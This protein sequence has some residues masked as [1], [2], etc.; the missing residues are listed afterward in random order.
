MSQTVSRNHSCAGTWF[1]EANRK[2]LLDQLN[3]A[4]NAAM[5]RPT[6]L[7]FAIEWLIRFKN[8]TVKPMDMCLL[9]ISVY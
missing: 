4:P 2:I 6:W 3:N 8:G 1:L 9:R 7:A 5:S